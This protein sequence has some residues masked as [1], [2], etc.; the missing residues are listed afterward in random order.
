MYVLSNLHPKTKKTYIEIKIYSLT[1]LTH[2]ILVAI[3]LLSNCIRQ[4]KGWTP[5]I[6][7]SLLVF[8]NRF[9]YT[10]HVN[11]V[12]LKLCSSETRL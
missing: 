2:T 7:E 9:E 3:T 4:Y 12:I 5:G 10:F 8:C 1:L 6:K 11:V